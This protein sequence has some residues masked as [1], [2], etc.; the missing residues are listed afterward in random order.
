M[1][2]ELPSPNRTGTTASAQFHCTAELTVG[3]LAAITGACRATAG[4]ASDWPMAAKSLVLT[5]AALGGTAQ[6]RYGSSWEK[7]GESLRCA[8]RCE[9]VSWRNT[10][11]V[12]HACTRLRSQAKKIR[13]RSEER[14]VGKECRSR[15]S[16]YH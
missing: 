4:S 8:A 16:P 13:K 5:G 2:L 12:S 1:S 11:W 3:R 6:A 9:T 15:W 14:R 7:G 10:A